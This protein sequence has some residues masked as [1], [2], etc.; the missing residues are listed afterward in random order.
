MFQFQHAETVNRYAAYI[1]SDGLKAIGGDIHTDL[2]IGVTEKIT[3]AQ[4]ADYYAK[5]A[6]TTN[7]FINRRTGK[8]LVI[9]PMYFTR[10]FGNQR[11]MG[12]STFD[13]Q[14][15]G[16][17]RLKADQSNYMAVPSIFQLLGI[18]GI[19]KNSGAVY[20]V[21]AD[22]AEM[23]RIG[24]WSAHAYHFGTY[25]NKTKTEQQSWVRR[26]VNR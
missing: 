11:Y 22:E 15:A 21:S 4:V 9:G 25:C 17:Y 23:L 1:E 19:S 26:I 8:G 3:D 5:M 7:L 24:T 18:G 13:I 14:Q 20:A 6:S 10:Y 2:S 12:I 16:V